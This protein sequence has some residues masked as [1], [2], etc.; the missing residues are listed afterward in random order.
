MA[1]TLED[2]LGMTEAEKRRAAA[3]RTKP[4]QNSDQEFALNWG[5]SPAQT[6]HRLPSAAEIE[7]EMPLAETEVLD[8]LARDGVNLPRND[9]FV[10]AQIDAMAWN[11]A[12]SKLR[13]IR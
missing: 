2:I 3:A 5:A 12:F 9:R 8:Q 7:R 6:E 1:A 10:Q 11:R 13:S 4:P